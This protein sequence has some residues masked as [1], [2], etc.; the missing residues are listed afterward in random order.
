MI[1]PLPL[2]P[3]E[4]YM[5]SDDRPAYPMNFFCR[6]RFSG[7]LD[8]RAFES[9][10]QASV[11]RHPLL[12]VSVRKLPRNRFQWIADE[13]TA[14]TVRWQEKLPDDSFPHAAPINLYAEAGLRFWVLAG[15][16]T[17]ELVMQFHHSCCD[18]LGGFRFLRD[19][20]VAYAVAA[21]ET[22]R[23]A[24]LPPLDAKLLRRRNTFG[25]TP[26]RFL[27][28]LP[29]QLTGLL[30][31][32]QFLMRSPVPAT[33]NTPPQDMSQPPD[34]YPATCTRRIDE[35]E[36]KA[37][38]RVAAELRATTNDLLARDLFLALHDWM[39]RHVPGY[40]DGWLRLSVPVNL[41]T[42]SERRLPAAN[43]VSMVFLDRRS[44]DFAD[45]GQLLAGISDEM[46]L[47]KR[48]RLGLTFVF[49]LQAC[50]FLP[51][52]MP[53]QVKGDQCTATCVFTNLGSPLAKLPLPR[54]EGRFVV[55]NVVLEGMECLAPI[56]PHTSAAFAVF[57]YAGKLT[58]TLHYDARAM[59]GRQAEDLLETYVRKVRAS[60][61]A[62]KHPEESLAG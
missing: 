40:D 56:R 27:R 48:R 23:R 11:A 12:A 60:I 22:S 44:Q 25:L 62:A 9:V 4:E 61:G 19:L 42:V 30:G 45:T 46:L 17:T 31:V 24:T 5:L 41:R 53:A 29:Q 54:R 14:P 51:G 8:R 38:R 15:A 32:R 7:R 2:A 37:L 21:G 3:F 16:K 20:L 33:P 28:I 59:T 49:S 50:R 39:S 58:V 1:F 34:R 18:G 13:T 35:A 52:G 10:L 6:V 43:A 47:I 57:I 36:T 55:G 26:W